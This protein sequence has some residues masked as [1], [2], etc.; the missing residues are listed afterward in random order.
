MIYAISKPHSGE[1]LSPPHGRCLILRSLIICKPK[2]LS[3]KLQYWLRIGTDGYLCSGLSKSCFSKVITSSAAQTQGPTLFV[4]TILFTAMS[5]KRK[6]KMLF[7]NNKPNCS[8]AQD[9]SSTTHPTGKGGD[10][11]KKLTKKIMDPA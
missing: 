8:A 7:L 3:G 1:S 6:I 9:V 11:V 10:G 2:G 4:F 5:S